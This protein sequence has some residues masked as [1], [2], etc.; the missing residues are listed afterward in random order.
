MPYHNLAG[1]QC[2]VAGQTPA[3]A[4]LLAYAS[5]GG[6]EEVSLAFLHFQ[7]GNK[8]GRVACWLHDP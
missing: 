5:A 8:K 4:A 2:R 1:E 7:S 3:A 6:A